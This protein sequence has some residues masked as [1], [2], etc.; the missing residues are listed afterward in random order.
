VDESITSSRRSLPGVGE[1]SRRFGDTMVSIF[2][3][4]SIDELK[5]SL[6]ISINSVY[7]LKTMVRVPGETF[8]TEERKLRA[9]GIHFTNKSHHIL[10]NIYL[11]SLIFFL[12]NSIYFAQLR[13]DEYY[14]H[15][16]Y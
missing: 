12:S 14:I 9:Q 5:T 8:S 7:L 15:I 16:F 2:K 1:L 6:I 10:R 13:H 4:I 3:G 11:V